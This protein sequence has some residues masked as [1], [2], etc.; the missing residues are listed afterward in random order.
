MQTDSGQ[1][2]DLVLEVEER[3]D[4]GGRIFDFRLRVR[5]Q[6]L[7]DGLR[8]PTFGSI[9]LK[10][11][12]ERAVGEHLKLIGDANPRTEAQK[13][14]LAKT[15]RTTGAFLARQLLP[16]GIRRSLSALQGQAKTLHVL[17]AAPWIPWE[18]LRIE[19]SPERSRIDGPFLCEAF[20]LTRGLAETRLPLP[21]KLPL[22]RLGVV[23]PRNEQLRKGQQLPSL[24][25]EWEDLAALASPGVRVVERI[26]ARSVPVLEALG[27]G[28]HDGWHFSTHAEFTEHAADLSPLQ[29]E[30][31]DELYPADLEGEA[32]TLGARRP[33]VFLNACSSGLTGLSFTSTGGWAS[34][35]L[36]AGAG[37][38]LGALWPIYDDRARELAQAF[39]RELLA[40]AP[41]G[42]ALRT[43]RASIQS[44]HDPTWLAYT[45]FAHPSAVCAAAAEETSG[46]SQLPFANVGD[47]DPL[48]LPHFDWNPEISPPGYL[49]RADYGVVRF[50]GRDQEIAELRSWC[51]EGPEIRIRLYTGPGGM[52]KTRLALQVA[53]ELRAAGWQAGF[54]SPD[55]SALQAWQTLSRRGGRMLLVVDYA[56]T[57]R[58]LLVAILKQT[59][60]TREGP[61]RV[62]LLAR[63][64][65]DW[66]EQL[67]QEGD[68]VG[69]LLSGPAT[70]RHPLGALAFSL[71][72]RERSFRY[73]MED[74][75]ARLN[76]SVPAETLE[77]AGQE[78][79]ER[80]LLL[81]MK[82]LAAIEGVPV[83]GEM[84]IL[85]YVLDREKGHWRKRAIVAG[86]PLHVV[87]GIGRAMAAITLSGGVQSERDAV[88]ICQALRFFADQPV[89]VLVAVSH[90]LRES[91]PG[92]RQWIEPILP[93]LLGEHLVQRE[94]EAG[95]DEL[96]DLVLGPAD[97][98][99][100]PP[101]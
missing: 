68:G 46:E 5:S 81:H 79:Y 57:R 9:E 72:E 28:E 84:G 100:S 86:L 90:L 94:M 67:K 91:Y 41:I 21:A 36:A 56:E 89:S 30:G 44:P 42:E 4:S 3:R 99:E 14:A 53:S 95:A 20:A 10:I 80:A 60:S 8:H 61:I 47:D 25:A 26:E 7:L 77:D 54:L 19:R 49:L 59:R 82:A 13:A 12:P 66:W 15:L 74:F 64:A 70:S 27:R 1:D 38:F 78:V 11:G 76:R 97:T 88:E 96:L 2:A 24:D 17:S 75:A 87:P 85:D 34:R 43:A 18:L 50:H 16:A 65:L 6:Q 93:D 51:T 29:L 71:P 40:G 63:A 22:T 69:E 62:I 92:A 32:A 39:Y 101:P 45:V 58:D 73:A 33:L 52:G 31:K 37:A 55:I 35:F 23:I 48:K 83:K 98:P